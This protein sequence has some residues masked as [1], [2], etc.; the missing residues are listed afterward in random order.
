[1]RSKTLITLISVV[2]NGEKW[3]ENFEQN[4]NYIS[5]YNQLELIVYN[6][7]SNDNTLNLLK[8][9]KKKYNFKI[10]S[11][12]I[13][14]G[15]L[16][17]RLNS[18]KLAKSNFIWFID[19][20]DKLYKENLPKLLSEIDESYDLINMQAFYKQNNKSLLV[21]RHNFENLNNFNLKNLNKIVSK[22]I[23]RYII[24]KNLAMKATKFR[25]SLGDDVVFIYSI[26]K[27]V[28]KIK[29]I[30]FPTYIYKVGNVG[31]STSQINN[32]VFKR[33]LLFDFIK[34]DLNKHTNS[35]LLCMLANIFYN[36]ILFSTLKISNS[37]QVKTLIKQ[38]NN[39]K[40]ENKIY[41]F[42][43]N[44]IMYYS[45]LQQFLCKFL[46]IYILNR[47]LYLINKLR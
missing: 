29:I 10:Y 7:G 38:A 21:K 4:I 37:T 47:I 36:S 42:S 39:L 23:W 28:K 1:M 27:Y 2:H 24:K 12:E 5:K 35:L 8:K 18:L 26:L 22:E 30:N 45:K 9:L 20:D 6:D 40:K 32:D 31:S 13:N 25:V 16:I 17:A 19:F 43:K 15:I 14:D 41:I 44:K 34:K 11:S 3:I 33:K 46:N